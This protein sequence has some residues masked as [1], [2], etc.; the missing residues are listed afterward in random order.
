MI[1]DSGAW[2]ERIARIRWTLV[3]VLLLDICLVL[4][5]EMKMDMIEVLILVL[6]LIR[7][8]ILVAVISLHFECQ[9]MDLVD[10]C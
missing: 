9:W 5:M 4:D 6:V 10:F 7:D 2:V 3:L 1:Y 8:E